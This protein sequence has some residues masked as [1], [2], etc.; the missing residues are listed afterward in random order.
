M[1]NPVLYHNPRCSKSRQ[2]LAFLEAQNINV[3]VVEYLKTP[4]SSSDI[5][6]LYTS[7]KSASAVTKALDMVRIKE[8][9]FTLAGLSK[10]S[11]DSEVINAIAL[12]PRLLE[13]PIFQKDGLAAVGRPLYNIE[14]MFN[15]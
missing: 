2:A 8:S 7:L 11:T 1:P 3:V 14:A 4:L 13:R 6:Q 15:D 5:T 9:E 10:V 12:F